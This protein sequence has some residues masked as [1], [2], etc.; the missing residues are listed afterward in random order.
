MKASFLKSS[1]YSLL[2]VLGL[3]LITLAQNQSP[4]SHTLFLVGDAGEPLVSES[5]IGTVL[6]NQVS[7]A[8]PNATVLYLGD[9]IYPSGLSDPAGSSRMPGEKVLSVQ[10]DWIRGLRAKGIFIPG[11]HD[12]AHWGRKGYQYIQYQ[13]AWLD[14]LHDQNFTLLPREGCPGPVEVSVSDKFLLVILD[15]QWFLHQY[16]KPGAEGPCDAK[17]TAEVMTLLADIFEKNYDK[18]II[19]A[20]H[21]PLITYGDHGGVFSWKDHLF[22]LTDAN[23][24]WYLPMPV[25]GSFYPLYRKYFG[26]IQDTSHPIY[27]EFAQGIQ[28]LLKAYPGSMYVAGHEH[29]LQYIV[30]DSTHYIVSGSASKFSDVKQKRYAKFAKG[31]LGFTRVQLL[32]NGE[33]RIEFFEVDK[34]FPEGKS[35]YQATVKSVQALRDSIASRHASGAQTEY[36]VAASQIYKASAIKEFFLGENYRKEWAIPVTVPVFDIGKLHGGLTILQKGGGQ[37]TLSLR[38]EDKS[39]H[40]YVIRSVEKF[41]EKAIPEMFRKTFAQDLVQDQISAAHPYAALAVPGMAEAAKI[42][43]T[44]PKLMYVPDDA[45]LGPYRKTFANTLVLFEERPAGDWSESSHFGNS[46]K[47]VNTAKVLEKLAEDNDHSVDQKFV[48]RSR[49]FDM[50]IGDW[51]RHDDQWRWATFEDKK[52]QTFRPIPRDR[53]QAFFVN[54]GLLSKLWSRKWALP[55]FEGFD[56]E[57]RWPSGLSFNA[58]YFDRSF[59]TGL[60]ASDWKDGAQ[61]LRANLSD[62]SIEN[63]VKRLPQNIYSIHGAEIIRKLKARRDAIERYALEHYKFLSREVDVPGSNKRERF[64]IERQPDGDTK[65]QVFK[66]AKDGAKGKKIFDR[67]FK[68]TETKEVRLFGLGGNDAFAIQGNAR[69]SARIRIIGGDGNDSVSIEGDATPRR[70]FYYDNAFDKPAKG[71]KDRTSNNATVNY[72]DRKA[73]RYDRV[74]PLI[75][76]NFN[77]DDGLFVGAGVIGIL[78]G[79]RK[80]PFRQ[81]HILT[82]S[83][84]P[85]TQSFN[86]LYRGTFADVLGKWDLDLSADVKSPNFVNNFFGW[87]NESV[88]NDDIEEQPGFDELDE[89]IDYYRYRFEELRLEPSLIRNFGRNSFI[90]IGPAFQRIE[91]EEPDGAEPRF[92]ADYASS[93]SDDLF[94]EYRSYAGANW[95]L[96]FDTRDNKNFAKRGIAFS[97][98]GRNMDG[99][100]KSQSNFSSYE[101]SLSLVHSFR[102]A[103]RLVFAVR[104][105]G[106]LN[107]GDYEFYQAQVLSGRTELRGYRKTR[108]YGDRKF[109]SNFEVRLRLKNFKSYLFPASFGLLGF[110]DLGRVWYKDQNGIDPSAASGTSH[111]WHKGFG[112][113]LWFTPFNLTIL[114]TELARSREGTMGYVRLGFMF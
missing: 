62:S 2:I 34:N 63:S 33:S 17:T 88:Y 27:Q 69:Q 89:S 79:F 50:V 78:N 15:T 23:P 4:V 37:Q 108:F 42:Y 92:I 80:D 36:T 5:P 71:L 49:L 54:E 22:P 97:I 96:M 45:G 114:S 68:Q 16:D 32:E 6:R 94:N 95:Q 57:I 19:V 59:L 109:Y 83:V 105:G 112:G 21:H 55:K 58:R 3:P 74:A 82:G 64:E 35:L 7:Q 14:S 66:M 11:N 100:N 31:V 28:D 101:S 40:E 110:H 51:D 44:N 111:V 67:T 1:I 39:G 65:V 106:G 87:G 47:I 81:R 102:S 86:F 84:A 56:D 107:R 91:M 25:I 85:R 73:F 10:T 24:H 60:S 76:A 98:E 61:E 99:L 30:K 26:H 13:Q 12:W 93:I 103:G 75:I 46:H 8:A 53:D 113:G 72:Y 29:A 104:A 43:H 52:A 20:A 48:L 41:P 70:I 18:R 9:N 90:K 77:P 38:L